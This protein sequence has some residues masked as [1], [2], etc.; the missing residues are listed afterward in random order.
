M[1]AISPPVET[2]LDLFA[3]ELA[4]VRFGDVDAM[5]L[6]KTRAAV[7]ASAAQVAAAEAACAEARSRLQE[8]QELLLQQAH[9]AL[10]YARVYAGS[11]PALSARLEAISLPRPRRVR[12]EG[13]SN[14]IPV[15]DTE[16]QSGRKPRGR[17]R[18][19]D[20]G[21]ARELPFE[22]AAAAGE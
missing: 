17:P 3:T 19:I 22:G 10:A 13:M 12:G 2:V 7:D 8:Q 1:S 5:T 20:S 21:A 11:D 9:R 4:D 18:K 15:A 6:S 14:A 16:P